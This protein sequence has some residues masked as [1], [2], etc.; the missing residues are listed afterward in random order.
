MKPSTVDCYRLSG[1]R[2]FGDWIFILML[3]KNLLENLHQML[4]FMQF[5]ESAGQEYFSQ[6]G[7]GQA[8]S[9][10]ADVDVSGDPGLGSEEI[11]ESTGEALRAWVPWELLR[12]TRLSIEWGHI[13]SVNAIG[14]RAY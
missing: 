3:I 14:L 5:R 6:F 12:I 7:T 10:L 8:S 1:L 4:H 11:A 9:I 13:K 2:V